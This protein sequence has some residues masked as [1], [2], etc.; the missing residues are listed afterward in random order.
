MAGDRAGWARSL[1]N[2]EGYFLPTGSPEL[3]ARCE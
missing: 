1:A 2:M 3:I